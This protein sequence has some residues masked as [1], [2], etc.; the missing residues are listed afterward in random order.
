MSLEVALWAFSSSVIMHRAHVS[1]GREG[2]VKQERTKMVLLRV[3]IRERT[4]E[5]NTELPLLLERFTLIS[6]WHV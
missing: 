2:N 1:L 6:T 3:N 5:R 4:L